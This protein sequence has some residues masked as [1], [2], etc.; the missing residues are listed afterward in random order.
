MVFLKKVAVFVDWDNLRKTIEDLQRTTEVRTFNYNNTAHLAKLFKCFLSDD[1][2]FYRIYIYTARHLSIDEINAHL[3]SA[4][5]RKFQNYLTTNPGYDH[6]I[7]VANTFLQNI[8]KEDFVALRTGKMVVN[9]LKPTGYPDL[10]QK[11]VD[12]LLGLDISHI[13]YMRLAEKVLIFSKDTDMIPAMKV[14]RTNGL[15]VIIPNFSE[16][17][18]IS[19]GLVKH[20]DLIRMKS[21]LSD[22]VYGL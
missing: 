2:E 20:S 11:Q 21:F 6:K 7:T 17:D 3:S 12:M 14:A 10:S 19:E 15:T 16:S 18:Y 9:G 1:E 8:V 5:K 4:Y 13:A 22:I